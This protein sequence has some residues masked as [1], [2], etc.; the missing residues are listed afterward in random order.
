MKKLILTSLTVAAALAGA[1][2]AS[3]AE[4]YPWCLVISDKTGSWTCYFTSREQCMDSAGGNNGFCA[5][6][7]PPTKP[8]RNRPLR[9]A[10]DDR[11]AIDYW[12]VYG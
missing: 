7:I 1:T 10:G 2:S 12:A 11:L 4:N 3:H 6:A 8:R 9:S 5:H